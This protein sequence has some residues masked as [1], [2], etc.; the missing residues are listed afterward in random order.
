MS[1]T[2]L[3]DTGWS[4]T[5]PVISEMSSSNPCFYDS[6]KLTSNA[7]VPFLIANGLLQI[8]IVSQL[9]FPVMS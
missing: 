7:I 6:E 3:C 9:M 4:M 8:I 5:L 1:M 2:L